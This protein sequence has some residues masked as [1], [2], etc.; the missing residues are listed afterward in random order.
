V[1]AKTKKPLS[2]EQKRTLAKDLYGAQMSNLLYYI[3]SQQEVP[4]HIRLRAEELQNKW[5][6]VADLKLMNPL[7]AIDLEKQLQ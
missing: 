2:P 6:S 4:L 1:K 7:T 5:D 3:K